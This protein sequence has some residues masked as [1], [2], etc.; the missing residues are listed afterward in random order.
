[1]W[2][3][4]GQMAETS[5]GAGTTERPRDLGFGAGLGKGDVPD[6]GRLVRLEPGAGP[7]PGLVCDGALVDPQFP[8]G[9]SPEEA[10]K[11]VRDAH[12][13]RAH[14]VTAGLQAG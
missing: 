8:L 12:L 13:P 6:G 10:V 3:C 2:R 7:L 14:A 11:T 1:M 4:A 9:G 5:R